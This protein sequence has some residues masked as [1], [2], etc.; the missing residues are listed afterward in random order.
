MR[1]SKN[2]KTSFSLWE[3]IGVRVSKPNCYSPHLSPLPGGEGVFRGYLIIFVLSLSFLPFQPANAVKDS[4]SAKA[5]KKLQ[6]MLQDASAERD[7]LSAENAKITAELEQLKKEI[8]KEKKAATALVDKHAKDL[9]AQKN[10]ADEVHGRL[11]KTT[12][13]LHEV[14]DKYNALNQSKNELA[15]EHGSLQNTQKFTASEL[16]ACESKNAKMFEGAK[17]VVVAYQRCQGKGIVDTF[18][19]S[20]PFTQIDSVGLETIIQDYEDKLVKQKFHPT[21]NVKTEVTE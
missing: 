16:K 7:R 2:S 8:D 10:I 20:E 5:I 11:D 19:D 15:T 17:Q 6:M 13:K 1:T 14:I 9:A 3:K 12:A 4:G 18:I 21:E